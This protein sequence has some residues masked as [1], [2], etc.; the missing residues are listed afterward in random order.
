MA[1]RRRDPPAMHAWSLCFFFAAVSAAAPPSPVTA[2]LVQ[3]WACAPSSP[4][5]VWSFLS[6]GFPRNNVRLGGAAGLPYTGL[7]LNTLGFSNSSGGTLNIWT[8]SPSNPWGQQWA[9]SSPRRQLASLTNGLCAGTSNS[10]G[11]LP[12]GTTVV[13]VP[14]ANGATAAWDADPATGLLHWGAD[15]TLCLDAGTAVNCATQDPLLPYCNPALPTPA[16]VADLLA[17]MVPVEKAAM[18]AASNNGVPRLGVPPLRYGEALHG[19]LSGCGEAAPGSTG[20]PTSFP[21]GLGLGSAF[22]RSLWR[23][24]GETIGTEARALYNQGG[25]AQ[26]MLFTPDVNGAR[27]PRW[28]RGMEVP[29]EDPFHGGEYA[30]AYVTGL[31]GED[32]GDFV[33]AVAMVK[34]AVAY[35][36]EGNFGPHDRTCFCANV[37]LKSLVTYFWPPFY[38]AV[39]RGHAGGI[40]CS[41]NGYGVDG[42]PGQASC[43][44]SEFNNGVLRGQWGFDGAMVTDGNGVGNLWQRFGHGAMNCGDGADSPTAAVR[45]GLRGGVDVELGETLNNFALAA[46]QNGSI[47]MADVDLALSRTLPWLFRLGLMDPPAAVPPAHLGPADVDT[48]ASRALAREAAAQAVVLL[49][50]AAVPTPLIPFSLGRG[51][52]ARLAVVGPSIDNADTLLANYHGQNKVV[53]DHTPLRALTAAAVASGGLVTSALGCPTVLCETAEGFPAAVAAA[54]GADLVVFVGGGGPWRG[55]E[56]AFNATEG[57][58]FDRTNITLPG[59]QEALITQLLNT[60]TPVVVVIMRGGPIAL[61]TQLLAHP[62][63]TT[64]LDVAYPGESEFS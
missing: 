26:G 24:V 47:T 50:N 55:G 28:G 62:R 46:I 33:R 52:V 30:A 19:V 14:C 25:I 16:R 57:E 31:Q 32:S 9:Y 43:A 40:M 45:Q 41:A 23:A 18:L 48:P 29:S 37:T 56:G 34:H 44:H 39:T 10:S 58:E 11:A 8:D 3:L 5:Q 1:P 63:L 17:R 6:A 51:G 53:L 13:Q 35:D 36:Q 12:A 21:T 60:G 4:F 59:L 54:A 20:C 49:R 61:S 64:L 42:A 2:T 15:P 22:N 38:A 27:D 7:N